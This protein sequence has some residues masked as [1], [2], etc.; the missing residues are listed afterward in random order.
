MISLRN[1]YLKFLAQTSDEPMLL[2]P[3][4]AEGL[5]IYDVNDEKY[6]DLISGISVS[7][8]GHRHPRVVKAVKDQVD[9]YMHV[10]VYGEFVQSPQAKFAEKLV[11]LLPEN[12]DKVFLV[13]SGSEAV[14]GAMKLAKKYTG[15]SEF[16]S[17]TDCYHGN[18]QGAMSLLSDEER[19][20]GYG[21]YLEGIS[22]IQINEIDQLERINSNTAAVIV[23]TLMGEA[24]CRVHSKEYIEKL[25]TKCKKEGAL[26]ILDEIQCGF[27]RTGKMF[28]FEHYNVSPDIVLFAKG[29]G[30]GMPIG[31]FVAGKEV[32]DA[33]INNPVLGHI[34]TFGGHPVSCAAA[35]ASLEVLEQDKVYKNA[36]E[37][38][39]LFRNGLVHNDIIEVRGKGLMLA[40]QLKDNDTVQRVI[41]HCIENGIVTDW[42][43]FA[44][45]CLRIA[46]PLTIDKEN[47]I[48]ACRIICEALDKVSIVNE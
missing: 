34:T 46:P 27:G 19:K 1:T 3:K 24:G 28:A 43:L 21:P 15:R 7:N 8:I 40:V 31:A 20:E 9:S 14:E 18:T 38:E 10:M 48:F 4:F 2:E 22:H 26:L 35:L 45:D 32:M 33:F 29:M 25:S 30:G 39:I 12:L 17:L 16:I 42:F 47:I 41:A 5:Y 37:K 13:N 44:A 6:L 36:I 23:E 11:E